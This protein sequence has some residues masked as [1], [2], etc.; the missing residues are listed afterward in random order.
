[1]AIKVRFL[2]LFDQDFISQPVVAKLT[3]K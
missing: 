1:M 2:H 3:G